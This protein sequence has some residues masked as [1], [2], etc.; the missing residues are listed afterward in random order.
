MM[1]GS[2]ECL[3]AIPH[4]LFSVRYGFARGVAFMMFLSPGCLKDRPTS[5][6]PHELSLNVRYGFARG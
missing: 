2:P 4:E 1:L 6:I 3:A 5:Y